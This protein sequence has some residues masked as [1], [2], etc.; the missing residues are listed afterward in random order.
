MSKE[1]EKVTKEFL[2]TPA[3]VEIGARSTP[4]EAVTQWVVEVSMAA[5]VPALIHLLKDAALESVLVFSRTKHG[6]DRIAR[7]L[8][9]G[10]HP[11]GHAAFQPH[12]G[13]AAARRSS[14]SSPARCAC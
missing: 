1:I 6:A 3:L 5:K 9:D 10:R 7:K 14:A 2:T 12:A 11:H 8:E 13:P 4:A